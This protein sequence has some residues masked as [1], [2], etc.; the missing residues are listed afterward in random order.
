MK[1]ERF[2]WIY[3][4][5]HVIAFIKKLVSKCSRGVPGII[6]IRKSRPSLFKNEPKR[7]KIKLIGEK[8]IKVFCS[9]SGN[10]TLNKAKE[11]GFVLN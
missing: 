6:Y 4:K 10:S 8:R 1:M 5:P 7:Q 2:C 11:L 9:E 3:T